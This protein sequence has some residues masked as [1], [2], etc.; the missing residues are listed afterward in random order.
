M[1][2]NFQQASVAALVS[3]L[4]AMDH[5]MWAVFHS[6]TNEMELGKALW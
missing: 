1:E 2:K 5:A 3:R 4:T 6:S